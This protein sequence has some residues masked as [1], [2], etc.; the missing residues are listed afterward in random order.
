MALTYEENSFFLCVLLLAVIGNIAF[1][2]NT[3]DVRNKGG[4]GGGG[5]GGESFSGT[6][7]QFW[8]KVSSVVK[9]MWAEI[10][11]NAVNR[12]DP[13]VEVC[14][15]VCCSVLQCVAVCCS[16]LQCVAVCCSVL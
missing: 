1:F 7:R 12:L 13:D 2:S 3:F 5:G 4:R 6:A 8:R 15:A 10:I 11:G 16:V 14:V 9:L